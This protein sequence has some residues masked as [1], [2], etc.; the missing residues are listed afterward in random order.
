VGLEF[1]LLQREMMIEQLASEAGIARSTGYKALKG[2]GVGRR[3]AM[4][5]LGALGRHPPSLPAIA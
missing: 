3:V 1:A 5:I 4:A 2:D